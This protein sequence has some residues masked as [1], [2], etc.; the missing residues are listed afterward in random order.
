MTCIY[1]NINIHV[2]VSLNMYIKYVCLMVIC[3]IKNDNCIKFHT[4]SIC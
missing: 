1:Y 3:H 4:H 2:Y